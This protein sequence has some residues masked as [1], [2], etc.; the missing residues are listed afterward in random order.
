MANIAIPERAATNLKPRRKSEEK[1]TK[2]FVL[3]L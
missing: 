3:E 2:L 1:I